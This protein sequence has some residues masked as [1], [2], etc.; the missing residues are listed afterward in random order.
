LV[1]HPIIE[2]ETP[3][4]AAIIALN[5]DRFVRSYVDHPYDCCA[6]KNVDPFE[7]SPEIVFIAN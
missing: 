7:V 2:I 1:D 6:E 5:E 4:Y 3:I